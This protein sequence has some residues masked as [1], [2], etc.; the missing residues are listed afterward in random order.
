MIFL[1]IDFFIFCEG[2][3]VYFSSLIVDDDEDGQVLR[4]HRLDGSL[5]L[6]VLQ[7]LLSYRIGY[8]R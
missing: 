5:I 6:R 7:E 4:I 3:M 1:R 2:Y 8:I